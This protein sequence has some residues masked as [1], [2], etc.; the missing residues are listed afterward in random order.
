MIPESLGYLDLVVNEPYS[1]ISHGVYALIDSGAEVTLVK[2]SFLRKWDVHAK[3]QSGVKIIKLS[4]LLYCGYGLRC[5][6][7]EMFLY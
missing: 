7:A 5:L 3:S 6:I 2:S 1:S 4:P